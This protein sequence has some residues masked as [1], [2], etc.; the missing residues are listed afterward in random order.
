LHHEK[1][2]GSGY[3]FG[4]RGE[5]IIDIKSRTIDEDHE[6]YNIEQVRATLLQYISKKP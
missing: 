6:G 2:D 4:Y 1:W 3:P 5:E